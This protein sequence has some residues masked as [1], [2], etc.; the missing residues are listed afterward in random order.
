MRQRV[1]LPATTQR[2]R[3]RRDPNDK[4]LRPTSD[5]QVSYTGL[6][7][8]RATAAR[9]G[10]ATCAARSRSSRSTRAAS[11][12]PSH[13]RCRCRRRTRRAARPR[14]RAASRCRRDGARLYVCGN[15]SNR[16]LEL[17]A[18]DRRGAAHVRRRRGAIRRR[19]RRRSRVREQ[20]G[21][22]AAW[23]G[24]PHRP[25]R[26]RHEV[27][28]DPCATS[29]ARVR[30]AS[31]TSLRH[32]RRETRTGLH[33][34][35]LAVSPDGAHVVCANAGSDTCRCSTATARSS[36]LVGAPEAK[37][38]AA[39]LAERARA[40]RPTASGS[41]SPT[42]RMNAIAVF[43][44]EPDDRG[45][46]PLLGL[47]PVGWYPGGAV[48]RR[49]AHGAGVANVKGSASAGRARAAA[50]RSSTA[51]STTARCRSC[52]CP[53]DELPS[54][55]RRSTTTCAAPAIEYALLPPRPA[56][57]RARSPSASASRAAS[58]HVVYVIKENRTYDQVL[59]DLKPATATPSS[60]SSATRS[61]PTS[62]RSRASSCCSTTPTAPASCRPT[63][64]SGARRRSPPTTWRR[65]SPASRA[66]I[67]TAWARTKTTRCPTRRPG[68]CG[69]TRSPAR[70]HAAQLRRVLRPKVRWRDPRG[71]ASPTSLACYRAW[72]G[73][74]RRRGVRQRGDGALAAAHS[75]PD[76]VGWN[77]SVPD[78]YRADFFLRELAEFEAKG[79][80]P[81]LVIICLPNDHTS[82]TSKAARRPPRAWPTT[83]SPSAASSKA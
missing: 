76:Y 16:L 29:P 66:A 39:G 82:G 30:S 26:T 40:S 43:D 44:F 49:R 32:A 33:A 75:P 37:R 41:T 62:T 42:A 27:R 3:R 35:D 17:D 77:M 2:E 22:A 56:S 38:P 71:R 68:S 18:R 8:R 13:T 73:Q 79:E 5:G 60:A 1:P 4:E 80:F 10:S 54:C 83:T 69:T 61:R 81:Q 63:A 53:D 58:E 19:A 23:R 9:S 67:P 64:T 51:T 14:S 50:C 78:Q 6:D 31:S 65:A 52:R 34:S 47:V 46:S 28:V 7:R 25:G 20:L 57:R 55:R 74:T 11:V 21:R 12:T 24:R 59:G 70:R 72:R 15:L 48:L 36:R 45:D